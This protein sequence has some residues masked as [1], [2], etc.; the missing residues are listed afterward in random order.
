MVLRNFLYLLA[1]EFGPVL[2]FFL[3]SIFFNFL[4]GAGVLVISTIAALVVAQVRD[5]RIPLF[6]IVA[7][8]FVLVS[9]A[10][11][12]ITKDPYWVALEYTIYNGLF[13][14]AMFV[15]YLLEKPILKTFFG[16][17]FSLTERGWN[18]LSLRWGAIFILTALGSELSWRMG[19]AD[20]WLWY[21]FV[22]TFVLCAFGFSQFFLARKERLP[23]ASPW[24]LK[25]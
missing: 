7:S 22:M 6:S 24:G 21:R 20:L 4:F 8:S 14:V 3:S 2:L 16:T 9:G 15:G 13:G 1:I 18:I 19:G 11:T 10:A 25:M 5:K 12:L 23:N 17:M